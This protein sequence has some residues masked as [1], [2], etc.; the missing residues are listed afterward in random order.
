VAAA[1]AAGA[2]GG[3]AGQPPGGRAPPEPAPP[4]G[5]V[6]AACARGRRAAA[7]GPGLDGSVRLLPAA[8]AVGR[9]GPSDGLGEDDVDALSRG[10]AQAAAL[11]RGWGVAAP[12]REGMSLPGGDGGWWGWRL[13]ALRRLA[14]VV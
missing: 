2:E 9:Y 5:R 7:P 8:A 1:A 4:R 14:A 10:L 12:G 11:D 13:G 3:R 6:G